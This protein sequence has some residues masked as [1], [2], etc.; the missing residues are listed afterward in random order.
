MH[1]VV[2]YEPAS[3]RPEAFGHF[4]MP[5]LGTVIL[6]TMLRNAGYEVSVYVDSIRPPRTEDLLAADLV[7]ISTITVTAPRA[8][9]V[10]RELRAKG[11]PVVLGGPHVTFMTDEALENADYVFRGEA[12]N[13]IVRMVEAIA[14]G[15]GLESVPGL[16]FRRDGQ[17]FH[18]DPAEPVGDLDELP[19]PDFSLIV[20]DRRGWLPSVVVPVQTSRG[21]P[22][23]C[24]FCSVTKMFG[25]KYR[26]R[27]S[28]LV[29][30][31]LTDLLAKLPRMDGRRGR[32]FFYDDH[33][34]ASRTRL[35]ELLEGMLSRGLRLRWSGQ[36]RADIADD[37]KLVALMR[38]AGC[39][40]LYIGVESV[41]PAALEEYNKQQTLAEIEASIRVIR[42]HGIRVYGMFVLGSD[43]DTV[44]TVRATSAFA[45][46][47][48]LNSAQF[49]TL[50]PLP[51]TRCYER[52]EEE[53][54]ILHTDWERYD[55]HNVDF[56]LARMEREEL[57]SAVEQV[58]RSFYSVPRILSDFL[59]LRLRDGVEKIINR[60]LH[61]KAA[62]SWRDSA[63]PRSSA[64]SEPAP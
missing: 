3:G 26:Y 51:G 41:N 16:S 53:G 60:V 4:P 10:A 54:R 63:G 19:A 7:G 33:L 37:E 62:R 31:E 28:E 21:C 22:Y 24:S 64:P 34:A 17:V 1:R 39:K 25:H 42:K 12:E 48:G 59:R 35:N 9:E 44:E 30:D 45:R 15:T 29:L 40:T 55:T 49:L 20:S 23:D 14:T 13:S 47:T 61:L 52:L 32:F 27:S 46:G 50:T 43:A 58:V 2:F 5:R 57:Q 11:V 6:G 56:R 38:R 18:N 8:Y 36:V